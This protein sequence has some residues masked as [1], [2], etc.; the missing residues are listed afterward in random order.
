MRSFYG[1][2]AEFFLPSWRIG[3]GDFETR[4]WSDYVRGKLDDS[5]GRNDNL[6]RI[7]TQRFGLGLSWLGNRWTAGVDVIK[8]LGQT[9]NADFETETGNYTLVNANLLFDLVPNWGEAKFFLRGTNLL[10][11]RG[12]TP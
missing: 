2:E 11:E 1:Y 5:R 10:D 12:A 7:P 4:L 9:R 6:P 8:H 3:P